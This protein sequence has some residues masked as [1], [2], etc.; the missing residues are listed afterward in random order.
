ME[1][2]TAGSLSYEKWT[3]DSLLSSDKISLVGHICVF[4]ASNIVRPGRL[5]C[6]QFGLFS[7][8]LLDCYFNLLL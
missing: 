7:L 3:D 5:T 1:H 4:A 2:R 6:C 8:N